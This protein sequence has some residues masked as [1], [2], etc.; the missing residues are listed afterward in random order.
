VS[1]PLD[2]ERSAARTDGSAQP[3]GAA[4]EASPLTA[5]PALLRFDTLRIAR[6]STRSTRLTN[7]TGE[8]IVIGNTGV[9]S[10]YA[11]DFSIARDTCR[12]ATLAPGAQCRVDVRFTARGD[13]PRPGI[14]IVE[15]GPSQ[16]RTAVPIEA[17]GI[18]ATSG[19][20]AALNAA[21]ANGNA[22]ASSAS[23]NAVSN[24]PPNANLNARSTGAAAGSTPSAGTAATGGDAKVQPSVVDFGQIT[25]GVGLRAVSIQNTS[26]QVLAV[27]G[28]EIDGPHASEFTVSGSSCVGAQLRT[29]GECMVQVRASPSGPGR[30]EARLTIWNTTPQG[31]YR[32]TLSAMGPEEP[33][34]APR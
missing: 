33:R 34:T 22:P 26:S 29:G 9:E 24:A 18:V 28:M 8:P 1:R 12:G 3:A 23:P 27:T 25:T 4:A 6:W 2:P 31:P 14:L 7:R 13:G 11:D 32:V 21:T 20:T 10:T 5:T 17:A 30:R 15:H 16:S 19:E